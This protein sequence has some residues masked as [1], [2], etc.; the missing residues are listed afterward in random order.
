[1]PFSLGSQPGA[2]DISAILKGLQ[3]GDKPQ[4]GGPQALGALGGLAK[5]GKP[6]APPIGAHGSAM[7]NISSL[8]GGQEATGGLPALIQM[9][10]GGH[11]Q[12]AA[13]AP[14]LDQM[15]PQPPSATYGQGPGGEFDFGVATNPLANAGQAQ[16][17]EDKGNN[18]MFKKLGLFGK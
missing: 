1:M 17:E 15:L 11:Q 2:F 5:M 13:G 8:F 9:L 3:G 18:N 12:Q 14:Q 10:L 6:E 4:E 7:G 16:P